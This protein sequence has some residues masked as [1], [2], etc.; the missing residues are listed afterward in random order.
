MTA[1]TAAANANANATKKIAAKAK[2]SMGEWVAHT[3][4]IVY[5]PE[6]K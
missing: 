4:F 6:N 2:K 5:R 1:L 3:F